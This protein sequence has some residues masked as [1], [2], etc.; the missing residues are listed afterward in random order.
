M[1]SNK[2]TD[3][4]I[5]KETKE[6]NNNLEQIKS[7]GT[8][9]SADT[10]DFEEIRKCSCNDATISPTLILKVINDSKYKNLIEDAINYSINLLESKKSQIAMDKLLVNFGFEILKIVPGYVSTE[11]DA[12]LSFDTQGSV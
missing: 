7:Y 10:A 12:R 6:E 2:M 5:N 9:I 1:E 8:V 4:E 11:V 3:L